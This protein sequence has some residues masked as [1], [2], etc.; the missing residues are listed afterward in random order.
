MR[1]CIDDLSYTRMWQLLDERYGGKN[2]Y[3]INMFKYAPRI[4]NGSLKEVERLYNV[5]AFQHHYYLMNDPNS[6]DMERSLLFQFAKEKL[7]F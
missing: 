3:T 7:K 6:L 1:T 5:F 2:A 4:K